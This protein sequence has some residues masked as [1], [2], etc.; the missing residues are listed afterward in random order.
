[1]L[2]IV[3]ILLIAIDIA[4]HQHSLSMS[5]TI[6]H[7]DLQQFVH[8]DAMSAVAHPRHSQTS[9]VPAQIVL[10]ACVAM[11]GMLH[12]C[13]TLNTYV[14]RKVADHLLDADLSIIASQ[15]V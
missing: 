13:Q 7:Q 9:A 8:T 1:M 4:E 2:A 15:H 3:D 6:T 10:L 11:S 12:S 14:C 5:T